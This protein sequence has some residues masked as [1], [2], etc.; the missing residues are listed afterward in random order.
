MKVK[1][2]FEVTMQGEPPYDTVEGVTLSRASI[3]KTFT[4]PLSAT[5]T[6][7]MLAAR[8]PQPTSAGYVALE[9]IVGTLD[10]R[11]G[12]FALVHLGL[13]AAGER[14][15]K[16]HIVPDSGTG[17]L[18]GISGQMDIQIVDGKHF[19]ELDYEFK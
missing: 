16:V 6:V 8:T 11:S 7:H 17:E 18:A 1:S 2:T 13:M 5:S 14:S 3:S 9:R 10:G 12:S 19:Y 15:L 4:G